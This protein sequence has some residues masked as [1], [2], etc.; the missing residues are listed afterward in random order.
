MRE[1]PTSPKKYPKVSAQG[2]C[3]ADE[4]YRIFAE[5]N[6][7]FRAPFG[8]K[9]G[10]VTGAQFHRFEF[11]RNQ[12]GVYNDTAIGAN[13]RPFAQVG[14][15]NLAR[16]VISTKNDFTEPKRRTPTYR[17]APDFPRRAVR[18]NHFLHRSYCD[19]TSIRQI[20][21]SREKRGIR[22]EENVAEISDV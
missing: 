15:P 10:E 8:G 17:W 16:F 6:L 7:R 2:I 18:I 5:R 19:L 14:Y 20:G 9:R 1:I 21:V 22:S 12:S 11:A 13:I 4:I 3:L